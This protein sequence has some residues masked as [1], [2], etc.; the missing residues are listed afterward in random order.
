MQLNTI[1]KCKNNIKFPKINYWMWAKVRLIIPSRRF[2]SGS[3][4]RYVSPARRFYCSSIG[5]VDSV[6]VIYEA[7]GDASKV[8]LLV[9][10]ELWLGTY[11]LSCGSG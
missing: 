6:G 2:G 7:F 5:V 11:P 10:L 8:R 4:W 9:F 1:F 3:A